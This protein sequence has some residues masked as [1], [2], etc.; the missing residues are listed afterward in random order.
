MQTL[1]SFQM[2]P[3]EDVAIAEVCEEL[4]QLTLHLFDALEI[5]QAKREVFNGLVEQ[6]RETI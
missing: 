4:D 6:V 2:A 5:L 1:V 3:A